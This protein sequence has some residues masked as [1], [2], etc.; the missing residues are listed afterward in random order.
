MTNSIR[1]LASDVLNRGFGILTKYVVAR[2]R[3]DGPMQTMTREVYDAG[4]GAA[5]LLYDPSRA[6]VILVRQFRMP[7]LVNGG[8]EQLIEVCAGK[9]DGEDP[10]ACIIK[11][12]E[13][14]TGIALRDPRRLFEAYMSPGSFSEKI[15]FFAAQYSERDRTGRGGGVA[16]S[17]EDIEI[18]EMT[19]DDALALIESG[20]IIDGKT[21]ILLHYAKLKGLMRGAI[22]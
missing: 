20:E 15:T 1:I 13:E 19:L 10:M 7:A 3:Y 18:L 14:E 12:A 11:E 4:D 16:N 17:D 6:T 22:S 21:I 9:L 8:Y 5:I 2:R